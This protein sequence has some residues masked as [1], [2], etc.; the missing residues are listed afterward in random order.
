MS[1]YWAEQYAK[2]RM[3]ELT[4]EARRDQ[5]AKSSRRPRRV[6]R[7][8]IVSLPGRVVARVSAAAIRHLPV[9]AG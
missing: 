3:S 4:G 7:A 1:S 8:V 2:Q 6:L 5:L 9:R